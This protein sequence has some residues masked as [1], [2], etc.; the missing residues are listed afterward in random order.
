MMSCVEDS[1]AIGCPVRNQTVRRETG[2]RFKNLQQKILA[3]TS[4]TLA[5]RSKLVLLAEDSVRHKNGFLKLRLR[6]CSGFAEGDRVHIWSEEHSKVQ[7]DIHNHRWDFA[8][9]VICGGYS[10]ETFETDRLGEVWC[11]HA[12]KP[13]DMFN[14]RLA[15]TGRARLR[16]VESRSVRTGDVLSMTSSEMHRVTASGKFTA[17]FFQTSS[18]VVPSTRVFKELDFE[19]SPQVERGLAYEPVSVRELA[20][21]L[22]RLNDA[23]L[24]ALEN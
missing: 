10:H 3:L 22:A 6:R 15:P 17:T 9:T 12:Y 7:G 5:E 21:S 20:E 24:L 19:G 18:E 11:E 2:S 4:V 1:H 23:L 13:E 8:S 14:Y 16:L